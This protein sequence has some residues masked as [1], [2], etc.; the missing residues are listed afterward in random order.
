MADKVTS[1]EI[2]IALS[3]KH[4]KDCF[5]TE[6]K[7]GSTWL[8][9]KG[10]M[11][12]LDALAIHPSWTQPCFTG[13]EIKVP[14][15]DFL[16]DAKFYTYEEVCNCLYI[17]CPKGMIDRTELP[18]TVGLMYY[19]PD[20]K[21]LTTRKKAIYREIEYSTDLLLYIIY[22]RL[23]NDRY[24]FFDS[25]REYF[26]EYVAQKKSSKELG[27]SVGSRLVQE[28]AELIKKIEDLGRFRESHDLYKELV[29]VLEKHG[30]YTWGYGQKTLAQNLDKRL[31]QTCP[32][33]ISMIRTTLEGVVNRLK[34]FEER[35]KL[36]QEG[37]N[38]NGN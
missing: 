7:S 11:K 25:K 22:S 21:T 23:S 19:D 8:T 29:R 34:E 38:E 15:G 27:W 17:V 10:Q 3:K 26:E 5:Y 31:S 14:R 2:K 32:E 1:T 6:C 9:P 18:E 36:K 30:F 4:Y 12:I 24:P 16:R 37:K 35:E 13:Y 20:K 33:D 28:N